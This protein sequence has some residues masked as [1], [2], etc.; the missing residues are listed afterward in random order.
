VFTYRFAVSNGTTLLRNEQR[1]TTLLDLSLED[2]FTI[3][4]ESSSRGGQYNGPCPFPRCGGIDRFRIQPSHGAY[5]WFVCNQCGRKGSAVDYLMQK[6]GLSKGD[7]LALVGWT[8]SDEERHSSLQEP[9]PAS[10]QQ[11]HPHWE[12]PPLQWQTIAQ[13][14][15]QYCQGVLWSEQ[16]RHALDYLRKRGLTDQTIEAAHLG[17]YPRATLGTASAWGRPVKLTPGIILPWFHQGKIWRLT[18]RNE[19]RLSGAGRYRQ[20]AGSANGL[21]LAELLTGS[22]PVVLVEGELDALSVWQ[23]C[24]D[25]V[26]VVATGTTQGGHTPQ[27]VSLLAT[28]PR[29]LIAFDADEEERG[30]RAAHWWYTRLFTASR[31]IPWGKDANQMLQHGADL[32][33]WIAGALEEPLRRCCLCGANVDRY[34]SQGT[35]YCLAHWPA[36]EEQEGGILGVQETSPQV[37]QQDECVQLLQRERIDL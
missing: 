4:Q 31:L 24:G 12:A 16:G 5:G 8:P 2:G 22:R 1:M 36:N 6:R 37:P 10:A 26:A 13:T 20:L 3:A 15:V 34:D 11:A 21:Y 17:Y 30:D 7:A 14:F 18:V 9:L 27:W 28:Q 25:L 19:Q 35:A 33:T 29:V 32:H 23:T